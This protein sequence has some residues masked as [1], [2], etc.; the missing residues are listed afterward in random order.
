MLSHTY[1]PTHPRAW[2]RGPEGM[3]VT[4]FFISQW[5]DSSKSSVFQCLAMHCTTDS[6]APGKKGK[7]T[8]CGLH[9]SQNIFYT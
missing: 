7:K 2:R 8:F 5:G 3:E 6:L 4:H 1:L 9:G